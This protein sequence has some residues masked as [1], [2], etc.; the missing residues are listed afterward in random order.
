ME[1]KTFVNSSIHYVLYKSE[2]SL[3]DIQ[4]KP[5]VNGGYICSIVISF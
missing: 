1:K 4:Q 2:T 5:N 3:Y